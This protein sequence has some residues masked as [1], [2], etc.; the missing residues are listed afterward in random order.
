[1]VKTVVPEIYKTCTN[2]LNSVLKQGVGVGPNSREVIS[3][4]CTA[5][6]KTNYR[7]I[8]GRIVCLVGVRG[9]VSP[10]R[11]VAAS[12]PH[13]YRAV[14]REVSLPIA[15]LFSVL[16]LFGGLFFSILES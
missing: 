3:V 7:A 4:C 12:L 16:C 13:Q 1:M 2:K 9:R 5:K 14:L 15:A 6:E 11:P 8:E 10:A